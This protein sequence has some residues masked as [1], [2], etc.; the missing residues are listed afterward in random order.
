M[1]ENWRDNQE[2][3]IF[4]D[5]LRKFLEKE[6]IP[7]FNDWEEQRMIPREF[8]LKMGKNGFLCPWVEEE[9]GGLGVG[10][11]YSIIISEETMKVGA[12]ML[13]IAL[14]S[15]MVVPYIA[16]YGTQEQKRR[17][18]PKC[19]TGEFVTAIAMSEPG[20]GSDLA[21]I[22]TTS[23]RAGDFYIVNGSKTFIS[24]GLCSDIVVV[25]CKTEQTNG[26]KGISLLVVE[27]GTPGFQRSRKLK[28]IGL[29]SQDT[30]ELIFQDCRIPASNLLGEEGQG[31][32][33]LMSKLQQERIIVALEAQIMAEGAL[34]LAIDYSKNRTAFGK[35]ISQF[36]HNAFKVAEM[37]TEVKIGRQ[38][39]EHLLINHMKGKDVVT[40][41]SMA[42]W[43]ITEMCNRVVYQAQQLHGGY[44]YMEEY[45][46][47]RYFRDTRAQTMYA[48]STE[49]MKQII[50]KKIGL[51]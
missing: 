33:Y 23:V 5:S 24:N 3:R 32:K 21:A 4:R 42:K 44:G 14:H 35:P 11:E 15:D 34:Q 19:I 9:Y 7:Y 38:F 20:T 29:H 28:K 47:A 43:W 10:F 1:T 50:A 27:E 17:W 16:S 6:G 37:A 31:W 18:L 46:I 36:Q 39:L 45:E 13:G 51:L 8:W 22:K 41:V 12:G 40:E 26:H 49:I 25:A 48:G 30:A 2:I